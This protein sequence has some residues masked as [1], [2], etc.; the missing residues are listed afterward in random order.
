MANRREKT[1]SSDRFYF[2]GLQITACDSD[3]SHKI[4]RYL[5][6]ASKAMTNQDGTLKNRDFTLPTK[7]I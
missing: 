7:V 4:E 2:L 5:L 1:G 3:S 6:L